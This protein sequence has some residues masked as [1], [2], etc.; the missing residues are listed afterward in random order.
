MRIFVSRSFLHLLYIFGIFAP[1]TEFA[2]DVG[3]SSIL[4]P[5]W[6]IKWHD[7]RF[8]TSSRAVGSMCSIILL[9]NQVTRDYVDFYF[10]EF[11]YIT[12][13]TIYFIIIVFLLC[14]V[15]RYLSC[16]LIKF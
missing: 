2:G 7:L 14:N 12:S 3:I 4:L 9:N 8:W 11:A 16:S 6:C 1:A 10:H 5:L 15:R 13:V